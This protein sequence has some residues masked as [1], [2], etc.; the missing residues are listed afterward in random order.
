LEPP[1]ETRECKAQYSWQLTSHPTCNLLHEV[2][3]LTLSLN[4]KGAIVGKGYF[5]DVWGAGTTV[6]GN[7]TTRAALKTTRFEH[8]LEP[9]MIHKHARDAMIT[10][11]L[12]RS[13]LAIDIYGYCGSSSLNEYADGG[14]MDDAI[15]WHPSV[16]KKD[17]GRKPDS[18]IMLELATQASMG[19]ADAHNIDKEGVASFAHTDI[20]AGQYVKIGKLYKLNDFNRARFVAWNIT[21]NSTT[22]GYRVGQNGGKNRSPEEFMLKLQSEKVDVYALGSLFYHILTGHEIFK[23]TPQGEA[24]ELVKQGLRPKLSD[25]VQH[26]TDI[27]IVAIKEAMRMCFLQDPVERPTARQVEAH[28]VQALLRTNPN[29][30]KEWGLPPPPSLRS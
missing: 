21:T 1:F 20:D 8:I 19:L 15:W 26:S 10:E 22:C 3:L 5:R 13:K 11:R 30:L 7:V 16:Q 2:D 25:D 28:L 14:D 23:N 27:N 29:A 18:R 24:Q 9:R 12:T 4:N 6:L 17:S